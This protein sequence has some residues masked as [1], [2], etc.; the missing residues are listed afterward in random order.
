MVAQIRVMEA[1]C[2]SVQSRLEEVRMSEEMLATREAQLVAIKKQKEAI[3]AEEM[4]KKK[5]EEAKVGAIQ[6]KG[7]M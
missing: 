7:D 1:K 2:A 6:Q 5:E 4:A 3:I